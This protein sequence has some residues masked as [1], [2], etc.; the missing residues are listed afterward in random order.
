MVQKFNK[1]EIMKRAHHIRRHSW[2]CSMS[3][4]LRQAWLEAKRNR[5]ERMAC[6][7]ISAL[8]SASAAD[9]RNA[10]LYKHVVFGKNDWAVDYSR[11]YRY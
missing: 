6:E 2:H 7:K 3:E 10:A 1:S 8:S 5:S 9:R 11:R 4:A